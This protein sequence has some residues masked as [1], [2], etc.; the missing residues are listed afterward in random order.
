MGV[1]G[2]I[3]NGLKNLGKYMSLAAG[4]FLLGII[5]ATWPYIWANET[6][7]TITL[8]SLF[9][10]ITALIITNYITVERAIELRSYNKRKLFSEYCS[11]FSNDQNLKKVSEW[12]LAITRYDSDGNIVKVL[13]KRSI[14]Y[15]GK[16]ITEPTNYEKERFLAFL[17]ELNIQI[18][19]EQIERKDAEE[20]FAFYIQ[21]FDKVLQIDDKT[22]YYKHG[23]VVLAELLS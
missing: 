2:H 23:K 15:N 3:L 21:L 16:T 20:V 9:L 12:L 14:K 17:I 19:N 11:R 6:T 22:N 13:P 18:K 1:T 5:V 4:V 10:S 7:K 8:A